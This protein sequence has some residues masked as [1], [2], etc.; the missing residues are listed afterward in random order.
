VAER[1][2]AGAASLAEVAASLDVSIATVKTHLLHVFA[3]TGVSR[4]TDLIALMHRMPPA[5]R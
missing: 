4:Q 3:K 5:V 2:L 1:L